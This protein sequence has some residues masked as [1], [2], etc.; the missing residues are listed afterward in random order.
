MQ[1]LAD[2]LRR[3]IRTARRRVD[4]A[5]RSAEALAVSGAS[6]GGEYAPSGWYLARFRAVLRM[7]GALPTVLEE[8]SIVSTAD[9]L[10]EVLISTSVPRVTAIG[11]A[12]QNMDLAVLY[13][14]SV[15]RCERASAT[16]FRHFIELP[17]PLEMGEVHDL[18]VV[19][20]LPYGQHMNPR[21]S[22]QPLR[23]CDD[24]DFRVRF[25][26]KRRD[27]TVWNLN[28]IPRGMIDD[29]Q[30]PAAIVHLDP[31]GEIHLRYR[32]LRYGLVYGIRWEEP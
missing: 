16:Y 14:G 10:T 23:R 19:M 6:A 22:I 9:G 32:N 3:D 24:F 12:E 28:G 17:H 13:G 8:R 20:T 7:D 26:G 5:I 25:G 29:Y 1:W 21:Y 30:E 27:L 2:K 11:D 31:D 18:G 4:E 15:A